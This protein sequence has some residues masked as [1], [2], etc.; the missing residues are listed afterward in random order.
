MYQLRQDGE[1]NSELEE[2]YGQDG[3][4][5]SAEFYV[6]SSAGLPS[7]EHRGVVNNSELTQTSMW[8]AALA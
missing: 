6:A 7:C 2:H 3:F 1:I 5:P 4:L 8:P